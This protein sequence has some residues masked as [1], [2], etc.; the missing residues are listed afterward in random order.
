MF[1][2]VRN[3]DLSTAV[4]DDTSSAKIRSLSFIDR[5]QGIC[6]KLGDGEKGYPPIQY[7][8]PMCCG[9]VV[10]QYLQSGLPIRKYPGYLTYKSAGI[11]ELCCVLVCA[12]R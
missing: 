12:K 5:W 3:L 10:R 6:F 8:I 4:V 7:N 9:A 1:W 2:H 11:L